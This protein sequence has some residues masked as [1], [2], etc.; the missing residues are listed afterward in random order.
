MRLSSGAQIADFEDCAISLATPERCKEVWYIKGANKM[1]A[2]SWRDALLNGMPSFSAPQT[3][4]HVT[5]V[6]MDEGKG[7]VGLPQEWG[8]LLR[9]SD[10]RVDNTQMSVDQ[11]TAVMKV[12]DAVLQGTLLARPHHVC[13]DAVGGGAGKDLAPTGRVKQQDQD[14]PAEFSC[15]LRDLVNPNDPSEL[16][17]GLTKLDE[18]SMGKVYLATQ[19]S[20]Q[21]QVRARLRGECCVAEHARTCV[22]GHQEGQV[23]RRHVVA[24]DCGDCDSERE[25]PSQHCDIH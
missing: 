8:Q 18:G 14:L 2:E 1:E 3:V 17:T 22:G 15:T 23:E 12:H 24:Y 6:A 11:V 10:I 21:K 19:A 13:A 9:A 25:R 4:K 20:T 16:F 5:H 7:F